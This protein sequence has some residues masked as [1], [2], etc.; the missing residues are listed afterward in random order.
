MIKVADYPQASASESFERFHLTEL[1]ATQALAAIEC[2]VVHAPRPAYK[3][4][5]PEQTLDR[6][7]LHAILEFHV[8][9]GVDIALDETPHNRFAEAERARGDCRAG[10]GTSPSLR[11]ADQTA[12]TPPPR[13]FAGDRRPRAR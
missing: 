1:E 6:D 11:H 3:P 9:A 10:P 13:R 4:S 7:A 5:M 2:R 8:E 12:P